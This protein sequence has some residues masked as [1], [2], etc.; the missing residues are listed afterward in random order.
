MESQKKHAQQ[1]SFEFFPPKTEQGVEK[2]RGVRDELA[3]LGPKYVSVTFGAGG[4]TQEGTVET[5]R[6]MMGA[7]LDTAPHLSCVGSTEETIRD[8][9]TG[10]IEM[11]VKRI[12]ALRGDM[13]SGMGG[14]AGKF[15][16]RFT[17]LESYTRL[18]INNS[19]GKID[20][21]ALAEQLSL[22]LQEILL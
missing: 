6:E 15:R 4:S 5:V 18:D 12:V 10:Y 3:Q 13:P 11:G 9:L 20:E 16:L 21:S 14:E 8:L 17:E 22:R 19:Q 1:F 2:L 7:G